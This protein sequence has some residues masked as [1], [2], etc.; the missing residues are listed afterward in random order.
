MDDE[1]TKSA[2]LAAMSSIVTAAREIDSIFRKSKA[3]FRLFG[4]ADWNQTATVGSLKFEQGNHEQ[5][6]VLGPSDEEL[7]KTGAMVDMIVSPCLAKFGNSSGGDRDVRIVLGKA[8]VLCGSKDMI[9]NYIDFHGPGHANGR[10][11][12][13]KHKE[14]RFSASRPVTIPA[15]QSKPDAF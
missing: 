7:E 8:Q 5:R 12:S 10:R 14:V 13:S 4:T 1:M 2:T 3:S 11:A 9:R 15:S 6:L